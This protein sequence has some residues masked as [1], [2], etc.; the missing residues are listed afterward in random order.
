MTR[1]PPPAR[2]DRVAPRCDPRG[3]RSR[4]LPV[5]AAAALLALAGSARAHEFR[6][7]LVLVDIGPGGALE[8]R[9]EL[10]PGPEMCSACRRCSAVP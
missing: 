7:A 6:A 4:A 8:L 1:H 2:V 5:L 3:A 9:L 10:P